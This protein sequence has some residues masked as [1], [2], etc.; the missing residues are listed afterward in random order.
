MPFEIGKTYQTV[1]GDLVVIEEEGRYSNGVAWV[2]GHDGE[3]RFADTGRVMCNQESCHNLVRHPTTI[4]GWTPQQMAEVIGDLRYDALEAF[5]HALSLKLLM[6]SY[7]DQELGR[8]ML[9]EQ[10]RMAG[11]KLSDAVAP[12]LWRAWEI[13]EPHMRNDADSAGSAT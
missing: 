13:S 8:E 10:L 1:Q 11:T 2:M 9:A 3:L 4:V 6:D 12:H 7:A 5:L